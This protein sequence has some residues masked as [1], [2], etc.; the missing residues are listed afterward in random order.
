MQKMKRKHRLKITEYKT[1]GTLPDPFVFDDGSRISSRNEWVT[2]REEIYETAVNL[3]FGTQP[4][5]PEFLEIEQLNCGKEH[6][7]YKIHAV[8]CTQCQGGCKWVHR[9]HPYTDNSVGMHPLFFD[10]FSGNV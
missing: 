10:F 8:D 4:P 6:R 1:K 2:R 7:T 3:Q 5:P 9:V